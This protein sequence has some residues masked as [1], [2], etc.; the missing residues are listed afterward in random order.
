MTI[1][2]RG[3]SRWNGEFKETKFPWWPITRLGI[4]LTFHKKFFKFFFFLSFIPALV[5]LVGIYISERIED[6]Q[7]MI[8]ESTSFLQVNPGY[9]KSYLTNDFLLF[10]I[11]MILVFAGSGL[12]SDD[13]RHNSLQLYFSRPLRKRDYFWGKASVIIFFLL[14][15]TFIPSFILLILKLIFAG[16]FRFLFNYPLL[17]LS[18]IGYCLL[19]TGFFSFYALFISSLSK[20]RRYVALLI[21]GFYFFSDILFGIFYGIFHN[22]YF[23]LLSLKSNLQQIG[24]YFFQQKPS[25]HIPELYSFSVLAG[26]CFLSFV[27][28]RKK[29]QGV[30]VIK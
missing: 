4:K 2:K 26:I 25:Y 23:S 1:R 22:Q 7:F 5:Y 3:Y 17:P 19:L 13:L 30:K 8:Q 12:I 11:I 24:A 20:N 29:V 9:F 15:V 6:F 10:M 21:F 28:L 14:A 18:I 16:N 27:V